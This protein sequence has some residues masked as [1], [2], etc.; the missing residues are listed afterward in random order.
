MAQCKKMFKGV[1]VEGCVRRGV[2]AVPL[3]SPAPGEGSHT[4]NTEVA[5]TGHMFPLKGLATD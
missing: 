3:R 2:Q 1:S 5:P 4:H